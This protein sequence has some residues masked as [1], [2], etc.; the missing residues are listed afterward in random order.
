MSTQL[1]D[2][3]LCGD[4]KGFTVLYPANFQESDLIA[5]VFSARRLPDRTHYQVVRCRRD[6]LVRSTPV[7]PES[8]AAKL[9]QKSKFCYTEEVANL[10]ATYM[11]AL[12]EV[13]IRIPKEASMLE[14]G[15][16][17]GFILETLCKKGFLN[18][19]GIE[20]G[21]EAVSK[22]V[23]EIRAKIKNDIFQK[24]LFSEHS[25]DLIFFF[26]TLDHIYNPNDFIQ[27]CFRLLKP[28]G[29]LLA[30]QH[31]VDHWTARLLGEHSPIIDVE[32][33]YLF[34]PSTIKAI[35]EKFGFHPLRIYSPANRI[36]LRHLLW[37]IPLPKSW[38]DQIF[39]SHKLWIRR[40]LQ[41]S[42]R[43]RIGNVCIIAEK[44]RS[45]T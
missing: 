35:F 40:L 28:G 19:T 4:T 30:Y 45:S 14:I 29:F 17:N 16:G 21:A 15:C 9:Y 7:L 24:G 39:T 12:E 26:Q 13:L 36:S 20:P 34:S 6:G 11:S 18:V 27:E 1:T 37:L 10:T 22:A 32:H 44:E 42:I 31:D 41:K 3:A 8:E 2:C 23:P 38:K 33:I 43:I 25:F 5:D